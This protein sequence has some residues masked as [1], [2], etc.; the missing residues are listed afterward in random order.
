M[1]DGEDAPGSVC[2]AEVEQVWAE[3][4]RVGW[5][6]WVGKFAE[7]IPEQRLGGRGESGGSEEG[8]IDLSIQ[9]E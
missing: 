8:W 2:R 3:A 5:K 4:L 7:E 9:R 1:L 6:F